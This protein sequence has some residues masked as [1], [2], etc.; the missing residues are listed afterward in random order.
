MIEDLQ[1]ICTS[2]ARTTRLSPSKCADWMA[3]IARCSFRRRPKVLRHWPSIRPTA[4]SIGRMMDSGLHSTG[5]LIQ[6]S[7]KLQNAVLN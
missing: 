5:K 1:T 3:A 7:I 6:F 4:T 2:S